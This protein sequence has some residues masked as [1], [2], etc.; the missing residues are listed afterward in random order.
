[1]SNNPQV[2]CMQSIMNSTPKNSA[3]HDELAHS[4]QRASQLQYSPLYNN[5]FSGQAAD[6]A[7]IPPSLLQAQRL[8][9]ALI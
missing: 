5:C 7:P 1:M 3:E 6:S 2:E 4:Q 8:S 9:D